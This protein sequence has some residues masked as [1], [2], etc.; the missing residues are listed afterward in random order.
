MLRL[1][2]RREQGRVLHIT[3]C[4][5]VNGRAR[6]F[7]H[8]SAGYIDTEMTASCSRG[9][10]GATGCSSLPPPALTPSKDGRA[11]IVLRQRFGRHV[12]G[13]ASLRRADLRA[14]TPTPVR[15]EEGWAER[16]RLEH[17]ALPFDT[18]LPLRQ[19][20][21]PLSGE[22]I[23]SSASRASSVR[24]CQA[25]LTASPYHDEAY[26]TSHAPSARTR[27]LS[28]IGHHTRQD[29]LF[30]A[31]RAFLVPVWAMRHPRPDKRPL[32][33]SSSPCGSWAACDRSEIHNVPCCR[34]EPITARLRAP[35]DRMSRKSKLR[36]CRFIAALSVETKT[37]SRPAFE[38]HPLLCDVVIIGTRAVPS[39]T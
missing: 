30:G 23:T 11:A 13:R 12:P 17:R 2:P 15:S 3:G 36:V 37:L 31:R 34:G 10:K 4:W 6:A 28:T 8:A 21:P 27:R 39:R 33:P 18:R 35:R 25:K 7:A 26:F 5:R 19:P 14:S 1:P 29:A 20:G 24:S 38:H 22:R 16:R 32:G 9:R